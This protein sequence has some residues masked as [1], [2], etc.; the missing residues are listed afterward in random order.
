MSFYSTSLD[1]EREVML[2]N[3]VTVQVFVRLKRSTRTHVVIQRCNV[4]WRS[5]RVLPQWTARTVCG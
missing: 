1:N 5:V 3:S 2:V 4:E